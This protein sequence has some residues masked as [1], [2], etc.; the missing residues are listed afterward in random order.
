VEVFFFEKKNQKTVARWHTRPM[1][2]RA[3]Q[4]KE[5]KFFASFFQKRSSSFC[6]GN[7]MLR[8]PAASLA[9]CLI[10][11]SALGARTF[12]APPAGFNPLAA[13]DADLRAYGFP[14]RP[15]PF[16]A[17][18]NYTAW[19]HL[20][21]GAK[22]AIVPHLRTL[23]VRH[24]PMIPAAPAVAS[25]V[26]HPAMAYS[27]NWAGLALLG[28]ARSFGTSS[29]YAMWG[30]FN[31][32]I[33][34]QQFGVCTGGTEYS[35]TWVGMDG[36]PGTSSDVVQAGTES[37]AY[38]A[39][40]VTYPDYYAWYEWYPAYTQEID[41]FP[42]SPGQDISVEVTAGATTAAVFM[43]NQTTNQFVAIGFDAPA[44]TSFIG[45]SA[46]WVVERPEVNNVLGTLA[47]YVTQFIADTVVLI[48]PAHDTP[49]F[50]G[51]GGDGTTVTDITMLENGS[52]ISVPSPIGV[53]AVQIT[54]AGAAN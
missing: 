32:P 2:T 20:V 11:Q 26:N 8:L 23:A 40:G 12:P 47:N 15:D 5:Q 35:A 22:I 4:A 44:G 13:S 49:L 18:R 3:A 52:A 43:T 50:G 25:V 9:A 14:P 30:Q 54:A 29:F 31:V 46:E 51:A 45:N 16:R 34:E 41:N 27:T 37:D 28:P 17:R 39:G 36:S 21:A 24:R 1:A 48:D 6:R 19:S 42:V 53:D 33:G 38:C 10:A 7:S